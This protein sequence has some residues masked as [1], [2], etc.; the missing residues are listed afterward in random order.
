MEKFKVIG[1]SGSL[2]K[3]SYNTMILKY[4]KEKFNEDIDL[5]IVDISDIPFFS[6]DIE[7]NEIE[8]V[9]ILKEKIATANAV[10]I[11]SPEYNYS[12]PGVLKNTI[13]FLSR[14]EMKP[15]SNKRVGI[16]S[17]SIGAFGGARMQ[18]D[19]RK[20]LLCLNADVIRKPEVFLANAANQFDDAGKII[21][22]KTIDLLA[23]F[24]SRLKEK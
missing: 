13:D 17:A 16:V 6:E 24:I 20:V 21:N 1:L 4:I 2:R 18:Y 15:L 9:R 5:E 22:E 3:E 10:I 7:N 8:S 14:G 19:L 12:I 23:T 11:A